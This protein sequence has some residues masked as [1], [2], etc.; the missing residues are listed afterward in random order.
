[1]ALVSNPSDDVKQANLDIFLQGFYWPDIVPICPHRV[2]GDETAEH[3]LL[4]CP[5]WEAERQ[6]HF[7]E[8]IAASIL[9]KD[10]LSLLISLVFRVSASLYRH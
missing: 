5:R 4:S 6:C 7:D 1:M 8:S 3:L 10:Y 2:T 9:F